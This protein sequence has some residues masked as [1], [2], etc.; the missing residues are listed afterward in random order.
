MQKAHF[1]G[2]SLLVACL[3]CFHHFLQGLPYY[4]LFLSFLAFCRNLKQSLG[5]LQQ[6]SHHMMTM[7]PDVCSSEGGREE[8]I[9]GPWLIGEWDTI[10]W[11]THLFLVQLSDDCQP[12]LCLLVVRVFCKSFLIMPARHGQVS[13]LQPVL[14]HRAIWPCE[15]HHGNVTQPCDAMWLTPS[16][17]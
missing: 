15:H 3:S 11:R 10:G 2:C 5:T 9:R 6:E 7:A 13:L 1:K 8:E 16:P 4:F 14:K 17:M 12:L